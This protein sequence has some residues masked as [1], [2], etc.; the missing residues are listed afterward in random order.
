VDVGEEGGK[1]GAGYSLKEQGG[2]EE[3]N[4]KSK[5]EGTT[6]AANGHV[7]GAGLVCG[8]GIAGE[9]KSGEKDDQG[10]G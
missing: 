5:Q 6:T 2:Q 7:N 1:G 3:G 9:G 8:E 10:E 4:G